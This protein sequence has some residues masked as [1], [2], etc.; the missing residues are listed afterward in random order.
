MIY[1]VSIINSKYQRRTWA[2]KTTELDSSKKP[3]DPS[4]PYP[5]KTKSRYVLPKGAY[6]LSEGSAKDTLLKLYM[7]ESIMT[8]II[9]EEQSQFCSMFGRTKAS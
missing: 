1:S 5:T 4:T 2:H 8:V 6:Y 3:N 7:K 9:I